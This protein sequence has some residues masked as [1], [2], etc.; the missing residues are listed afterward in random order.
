MIGHFEYHTKEGVSLSVDNPA[1]SRARVRVGVCVI[2]KVNSSHVS[3]PMNI[4][5][6]QSD[7][8]V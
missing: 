6:S 5:D 4:W 2:D 3:E 1:L 7:D 8:S